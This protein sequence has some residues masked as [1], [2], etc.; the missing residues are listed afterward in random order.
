MSETGLRERKKRRMYEVVSD[1]AV[2]LFLEKG[3]DAVSVAEVAAAAEISKP[4]LFRYFPAKE[5]L[6]LYRI[7]DHEGEAAR[8]VAEGEGPPV[9]ALRRHF[10][11]GLERN[12]PVTG[13]NDHPQVLAFHALLYGT[14]SL[15]A[16][17]HTHQERSE[18]ALAEVLGGD[19]DARLAAGQIMAVLRVLAL[20]NWRRIAAGERVADVRAD[21]VAAADRAFGWLGAGLP[22][23]GRSRARGE[24]E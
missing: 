21:A 13:L 11:E 4:T 23:V 10:L 12:D 3:F 9:E 2:R 7:A 6:V 22:P 16:R 24:S 20:E 8:V 14:P 1:V 15:V 17:A 18:A 19:L 5:D